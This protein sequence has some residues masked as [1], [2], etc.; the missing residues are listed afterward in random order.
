MTKSKKIPQKAVDRLQ[1]QTKNSAL[2]QMLVVSA[3]G[4]VIGCA[5]SYYLIF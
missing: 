3:L 2:F 4:A 5:I 1:A